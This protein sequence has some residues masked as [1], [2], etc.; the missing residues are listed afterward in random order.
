MEMPTRLKN[1]LKTTNAY[2][3]ALF[4]IFGFAG[5]MTLEAQAVPVWVNE[6][7]KA[8][9]SRDWVAVVA[10]GASQ[11]QAES[12]AMNALARAFKTDVASLTQSS[13][14]FS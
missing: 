5:L 7:E 4:F 12:A 2:A 1:K 13:Q 9:P 3:A 6:L 10:N 14:R 8:F 11:P